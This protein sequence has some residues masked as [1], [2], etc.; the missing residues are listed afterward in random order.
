MPID[1][2]ALFYLWILEE[3]SASDEGIE[4]AL[5]FL[6]C[7]AVSGIEASTCN[8]SATCG[9]EGGEPSKPIVEQGSTRN[10][11]A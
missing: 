5:A 10:C 7:E 11:L 8:C 3:P 9:T 6:I 1:P 2:N 4:H